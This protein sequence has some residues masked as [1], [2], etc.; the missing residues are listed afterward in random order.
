[1]SGEKGS[2]ADVPGC[3]DTFSDKDHSKDRSMKNDNSMRTLHEPQDST[4]TSAAAERRPMSEPRLIG[5]FLPEAI[6]R[7]IE[8][9]R[10]FL[11]DEQAKHSP[12]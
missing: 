2:V 5:E 1:M 3:A 9:H 4:D 12:N 10:R 7:I 11:A 8:R 6:D